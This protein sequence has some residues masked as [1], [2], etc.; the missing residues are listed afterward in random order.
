[1]EKPA[2]GLR[3]ENQE[4]WPPGREDPRLAS[5]LLGER[6]SCL[7]WQEWPGAKGAWAPLCLG[8]QALLTV[9]RMGD[10]QTQSLLS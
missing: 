6:R 3:E 8:S 4:R 10:R 9:G 7:G 2:K 1:M 5:A